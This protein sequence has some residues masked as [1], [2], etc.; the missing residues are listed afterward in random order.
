ML[1]APPVMLRAS[2]VMLRASPV[3]LRVLPCHAARSR[4]IQKIVVQGFKP[5]H[6]GFR[7]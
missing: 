4:S 5:G 7:D 3:M 2:P 6:S 1:R